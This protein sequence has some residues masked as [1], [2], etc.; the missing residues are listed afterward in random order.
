MRC[1][2][3]GRASRNRDGFRYLQTYAIIFMQVQRSLMV[4]GN[5]S[6]QLFQTSFGRETQGTMAGCLVRNIM[7][8]T[9]HG[10]K[11]EIQTRS[12]SVELDDARYGAERVRTR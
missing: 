8:R 12:G 1:G 2:Q 10:E 7:R 9:E 6:R 11:E 5:I 4:A 3:S